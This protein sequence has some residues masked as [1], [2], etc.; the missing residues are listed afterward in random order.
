M[1]RKRKSLIL[2]DGSPAK[3]GRDCT[4]LEV[5]MRALLAASVLAVL[6]ATCSCFGTFHTARVV[7]FSAGAQAVYVNGDVVPGLN[8]ETGLPASSWPGLGVNVLAYNQD[9]DNW[10]LCGGF[11]LQAPENGF[12]DIAV[13]QDVVA[14]FPSRTALLAS[15]QLGGW[16][17]YGA[18]GYR[19]KWED[20]GEDGWLDL[21]EVFGSGVTA[22]LGCIYHLSEGFGPKLGA[23]L[24]L[25]KGFIDPVAGV[26]LQ[27]GF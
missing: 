10:G 22:T 11:R 1:P 9:G 24:E 27:Y 26:T 14:G 2:G 13:E 18:L 23:E 15:R 20:E 7:P 12:A 16:E 8:V 3:A 17:P 25:G 5:L 4:N 21:E 6:L 19:P